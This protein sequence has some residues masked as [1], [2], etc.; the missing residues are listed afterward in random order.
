MGERACRPVCHSLVY[1]SQRLTELSAKNI[2]Q[3]DD[4]LQLEQEQFE[5]QAGTNAAAGSSKP[6]V[7]RV[8]KRQKK[9]EANDVNTNDNSTSVE[10]E[11]R[12]QSMRSLLD[13]MNQDHDPQFGDVARAGG[14]N[15]GAP[16]SVPRAGPMPSPSFGNP[17][18]QPNRVQQFLGTPAPHSCVTCD[19]FNSRV[20]GIHTRYN[21]QLI[22]IQ[23]DRST[24]SCNLCSSRNWPCWY[25]S[26]EEK[27]KRARLERVEEECQSLQTQL[28]SGLDMMKK[29]NKD[30]EE[31]SRAHEQAVMSRDQM[32]KTC[33]QTQ[34]QWDLTKQELKAA[35]DKTHEVQ[36]QAKESHDRWKESEARV[37]QLEHQVTQLQEQ[38]FAA[39]QAA[40]Q[41]AT[42]TTAQMA[43]QTPQPSYTAHQV[44]PVSVSRTN[45][46]PSYAHTA[47]TNDRNMN[48]GYGSFYNQ[49]PGSYHDSDFCRLTH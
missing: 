20:S 15:G 3:S 48:P 43:R 10:S 18:V 17:L 6:T 8:R 47:S 21:I 27:Q 35:Q 40:A 32:Q 1:L 23:C 22:V 41:V 31:T 2:D 4:Q 14:I 16:G 26:T 24:P 39:S 29:A 5:A 30:L 42:H 37:K 13:L 7:K 49:A 44:P 46:L 36:K 9:G 28:G 45:T 34:Q 33:E 12:Q 38:K 11:L 25:V 19:H